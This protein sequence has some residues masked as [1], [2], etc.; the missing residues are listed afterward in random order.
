M[1]RAVRVREQW[2]Q[3]WEDSSLRALAAVGRC[4]YCA[5]VLQCVW[6]HWCLFLGWQCQIRPAAGCWEVLV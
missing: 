5:V 6:S 1:R 4:I 2:W 3:K